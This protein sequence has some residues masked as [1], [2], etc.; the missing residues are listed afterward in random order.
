LGAAITGITG[1]TLDLGMAEVVV[2]LE[3]VVMVLL[4]VLVTASEVVDTGEVVTSASASLGAE[5]VDSVDSVEV[6]MEVVEEVE[7]VLVEVNADMILDS[8]DDQLKNF[9]SS[10]SISLSDKCSQESRDSTDSA[11]ATVV[12]AT[13]AA[14]VIAA[15]VVVMVE[16]EVTSGTGV[17]EVDSLPF[18]PFLSMSFLY[19][20]GVVEATDLVVLVP[21]TGASVTGALGVELGAEV[22]AL[23]EEDSH[24]MVE[25]EGR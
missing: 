17:V 19:S 10:A 11:L 22:E 12:A 24:T 18:T 2:G 20:K 16:V 1:T 8:S 9:S 6:D 13:V 3:V 5:V 21:V 15:S 23:S 25:V 7:E 14:T 4:V